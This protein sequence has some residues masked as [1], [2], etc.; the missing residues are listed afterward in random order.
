MY[1]IYRLTGGYGQLGYGNTDSIGNEADEMGDYLTDI[2]LG[3]VLMGELPFYAVSIDCGF[4]FSCAV[5]AAAGTL[6]LY[7]CFQ[8]FSHRIF[9]FYMV[10]T[11][12][13]GSKRLRPA[14]SGKH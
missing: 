8:R 7:I 14:R 9:T 13:L 1:S 10:R 4:V 5:S 2:E 3:F 6:C 11:Q 12:M